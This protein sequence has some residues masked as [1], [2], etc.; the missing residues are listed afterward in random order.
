MARNVQHLQ[1]LDTSVVAAVTAA[2]VAAEAAA[3]EAVAAE[4]VVAAVAV[5]AVAAAAIAAASAVVPG[6]AAVVVAAVVAV[7][8]NIVLDHRNHLHLIH[9]LQNILAQVA[10]EVM[11]PEA[12]DCCKQAAER[13]A[14][15]LAIEVV[16]EFA[17]VADADVGSA[18]VDTTAADSHFD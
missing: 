17:A 5:V 8:D 2:D 15:V 10:A 18:S 13:T 11:A 16:L 9:F 12:D 4:A 3:A 6:C 7:V 1:I 14:E